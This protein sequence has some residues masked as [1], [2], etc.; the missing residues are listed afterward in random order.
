MIKLLLMLAAGLS[1]DYVLKKPDL[2]LGN[3]DRFTTQYSV[4][5]EVRDGSHLLSDFADKELIS[6]YSFLSKMVYTKL[7]LNS[8]I[9][10]GY[11]DMAALSVVS[12]EL[13]RE[14]AEKKYLDTSSSKIPLIRDSLTKMVQ[15]EMGRRD[16]L[17][18]QKRIDYLRCY[19]DC[20]MACVVGKGIYTQEEYAHVL[21]MRKENPEYD[22]EGPYFLGGICQEI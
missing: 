14:E 11:C 4:C 22:E 18:R 20:R 8:A 10:L 13:T 12:S 2:L 9:W 7:A 15:A 1:E 16:A 19:D 3:I 6:D 21:A 5:Q 17:E